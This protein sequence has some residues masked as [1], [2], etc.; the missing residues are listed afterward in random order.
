MYN[1]KMLAMYIKGEPR[2]DLTAR[3]AAAYEACPGYGLSGHAQRQAWMT[4]RHH[5][6]AD[7]RGQVGI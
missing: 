4:V 2:T 1:K 6:H 7:A 3:P 5:P